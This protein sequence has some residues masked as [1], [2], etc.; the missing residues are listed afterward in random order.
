MKNIANIMS[1]LN[2][3]FG[4]FCIY[5]AVQGKFIVSAAMVM[6]SVL[7]DAFDGRAAR[8]FN[9]Q[10]EL[11]KNLDSLC[12]LVG[13]GVA[14]GFLLYYFI[15]PLLGEFALIFTVVF[16]LC[17]AYRLARFNVLNIHDYYVGVPITFAG[18]AVG[19]LAFWNFAIPALLWVIIALLLS[20][21][22][23]CKLKV[24]KI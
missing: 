3:V 24:K 20:Y 9:C 15:K 18:L 17:G 5:F 16:A 22:M 6:V 13:F 11:G 21:L 1:M 10:S 2:L 8:Y 7:L 19:F 12:D 14:P 23:V 4:I